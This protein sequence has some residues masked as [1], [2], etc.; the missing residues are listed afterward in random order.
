LMVMCTVLYFVLRPYYERAQQ[1]DLGKLGDYDMTTLFYDIHGEEIGRVFL[2]DRTLLAHI[3]I[4]DMMRKAVVAV[5]DKRFYLHHGIDFQ[6]LSR[7]LMTNVRTLSK[8]QGGSTITQQL[9][10]HLIGNFEKTMDRKLVEA[11]LARRIEQN[12]TK[13]QILD[14]YLNRIYFGKGYF[15]VSASAKGYFGKAS[16]ELTIDECALLA[17]IIKSPNSR[18]PRNNLEKARQWRNAAINKMKD[19]KF[20]S[21]EQA[22]LAKASVIKLAPV[23]TVSLRGGVHSYFMAMALKELEEALGL[24]EESEIPQ[25]LRVQTTLDLQLQRS[26]ELQAEKKLREVEAE[27]AKFPDDSRSDHGPLQVAALIADLN[28]GA[29]RAV[30]GGRD[31]D[32]SPFN[33]ATMARRE[34]GA[35]L[36]P[37]LYALASEQ[38]HLHPA[39]MINASFLQKGDED[40]LEEVS[41]GDPNKDFT[42]RFLTM[43]DALAFANKACATRIGLQ[44]GVPT[45]LNWLELAGVARPIPDEKESLRSMQ[46]RTLLEIISLYQLLGNS[47][48][49]Q[50][51]YCINSVV[52]W[53]NETIYSVK[54]S[55]GQPLLQ[56]QTAQQMT[57]TLQAATREGTASSLSKDFSFPA[58]VVGMTGYSEGYRDSWFVGYTPSMVAGVWIGYDGSVPLGSKAIATRSAL[59]LWANIMQQALHNDPKGLA[60]PIP[61]ILSKVEIDRRTGTVRGQGFLSPSAGGIFVYLDRKQLNSLSKQSEVNDD[62]QKQ[63]WSDWL[64]TMVNTSDADIPI[65]DNDP[66]NI[67]PAVA[68][69]R[70]PALR[71]NILS[72]DNQMLAMMTESQNLV[73]SWPAP[74]IAIDDEEV[75]VWVRKHLVMAE[76]WLGHPVELLDS[77]LRAQYRFQRFHPIT[78]AENLTP[79]QIENFKI[80]PLAKADFNLQGVPRRIYPSGRILSHA[81]GYLRRTQ[82]RNQ[83]Q[84]Q[85]AEVIYDD[86]AGAY[87]LEEVYETA[88]RGKDGQLSIVTTPEGFSRKATVT[89][90]TTAGFNVR[91][92]ID[93][94]IQAAAEKSM[95]NVRAGAIVVLDVN[96]GDIV[97]M[98]SKPDFDPN[99]FIP[100]LPPE[101]WKALV[102]E[103]KNPLL[104]RAYRQRLPPGSTFKV[105]TSLAAMQ[106]GVFD[107][108]RII[109]CPGYYRVGNVTFRFPL[110]T[111]PVSYRDALIRSYNTYFMDLGL[112]AGRQA[113]IKTAQD[114]GVGRVS[115]VN[116]PGEAP[117]L[118]PDS[119]FVKLTHNRSMGLGDVANSSIGQGDVLATPLQMANWMAAVANEGTLYKTRLVS[120][121]EDS[122]GKAVTVF[123]T[124]ILNRI[125]L[126]A[127]PLREL[128]EALV[129]VV[130][131]GTATSAQIRGVR[132]AA[133]TGTAQVGSK[134]QPRQIAWTAGYIPADR[135]QYSFSVMIEGDIDQDLHGGTDSAPLV[136]HIFSKVYSNPT[137]TFKKTD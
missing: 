115:G 56:P 57:L 100:A 123:P 65:S 74:E 107:S 12:Y 6:G 97:A 127:A 30:V 2:E 87:G 99:S 62:S 72:A 43:Q 91:T 34:N 126:P 137:Q 98:V 41:L 40:K 68:Q 35:L 55:E 124:E 69:Y 36:H 93:S 38:L 54:H 21:H 113:M 25:G 111:Q 33:R 28:D 64:S 46:P 96:T 116:L 17:G 20:L 8:R 75:Q 51:T 42:K 76:S 11:F 81:L 32:I 78:V 44:I 106:A 135:P 119:A 29:I 134:A 131:E 129:G 121:L 13:H 61:P 1:Y 128:K 24:E 67:I 101:Q 136:A 120:Q 7:A 49:R 84:Y 102:A 85:A 50:K 58:P 37:F 103:K 130:E 5:E 3:Q 73:L 122:T 52:N 4:P 70:I 80:S 94:Q 109:Q 110:E 45:F 112:R 53:R 92:T 27:L 19:E 89:A 114:F 82:G 118:M 63:A 10:K 88:L 9:A 86:Y 48:V 18:S 132:I 15:G 105:I 22:A 39:S 59:P 26:A 125:V 60:F 71:G 133:K 66:Q 47:G 95:E 117:G 108:N 16:S 104:N 31:Y 14:F 23:L 77:E 90:P 83:R 79:A